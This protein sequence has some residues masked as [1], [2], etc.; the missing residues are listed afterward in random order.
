MEIK[1]MA[2]FEAFKNLT[3]N[4]ISCFESNLLGD[5]KLSCSELSLLRTICESEKNNQKI[6][7]TELADSLKI[8]KSAASQ[9]VSKL[10]KKGL[11]KRKINI[12]DKKINYITLSECV[13]ED[14]ENRRREC[15]DIANKVQEKMGKEDIKELSRLLEKLNTIISDIR[16]D[17]V[18]C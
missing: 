9:L 3:K 10:E 12:F 5:T 15:N 8:T 18:M 16:K 4:I 7:V 1:E 14:Y 11:I 17:D 2:I 6:N 13:M